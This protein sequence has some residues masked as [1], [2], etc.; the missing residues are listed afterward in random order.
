[1]ASWSRTPPT[2]ASRGGSRNTGQPCCPCVLPFQF[3]RQRLQGLNSFVQQLPQLSAGGGVGRQPGQS[4]RLGVHTVQLGGQIR[5]QGGI[6]GQIPRPPGGRRDPLHSLLSPGEL[7]SLG[8]LAR[9]RYPVIG[10]TPHP[11][12]RKLLAHGGGDPQWVTPDRHCNAHRG[13]AEPGHCYSGGN[14]IRGDQGCHRNCVGHC[15]REH[16]PAPPAPPWIVRTSRR[17]PPLHPRSLQSDQRRIPG[18]QGLFAGQHGRQPARLRSPLDGH[19]TMLP[20]YAE[21]GVGFRPST[22]A[23]W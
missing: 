18:T 17:K 20:C 21:F 7:G 8:C 9:R 16:A 23:A 12:R 13:G 1:M 10:R 15:D 2:T 22:V 3:G 6:R 11:S 4:P 19:L 5:T 14:R